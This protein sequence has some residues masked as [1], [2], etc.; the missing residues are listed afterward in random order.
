MPG[1]LTLT[2]GLYIEITDKGKDHC[3]NEVHQ[4]IHHGIIQSQV[5]ISA[6]S[7]KLIAP[8]PIDQKRFR[9][10]ADMVGNVM[11]A[12]IS[13]TELNAATTVSFCISAPKKVSIPH[14]KNSQSTPMVMEKQKAVSAI[15]SGAKVSDTRLS[16]FRIF[17]RENPIAANKNPF[18]VCS[19]VSQKGNAR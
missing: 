8:V 6:H 13:V 3:A 14:S 5:Q 19:K 16:S 12:G 15:Y 18:T 7:Q 4:Q 2:F 11:S 9:Y 10:V 1:D 17:T